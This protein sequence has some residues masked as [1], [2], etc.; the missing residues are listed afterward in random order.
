MKA[1]PD[2]T[3]QRFGMLTVLRRSR[4]KFNNGQ[5]WTLRCD[6]GKIIDLVRSDFD[7]TS[8]GQI[9]C[10]CARKR[11]LTGRKISNIAGQKFGSLT[12]IALTGK[13]D[14]HN[15][16]TWKLQ[17]NCGNTC[18]LSLS[19]IRL[20]QSSYRWINC[21]D[22]S[23]HPEFWLKHPPTPTPYPKEASELLTKYLPLTELKYELRDSEIEDKKRDRLIRAAWI[24]TYRRQQGENIT[25]LHENRI[26]KKHLRYCSIDVFWQRKLEQHGGLLY[27]ANNEKKVIGDAMTNLTPLDYPVIETQGIKM[28]SSPAKRLKFKRC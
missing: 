19:S 5:G 1:K 20:R 7:R 22:R 4:K 11:G 13:R 10:G 28:M 9:S 21:G 18:E 27:N 3:G 6:C 24:I 23:K 15:K 2:C 26:I 12:A 16:P 14:K 25:E 17:C 8:C